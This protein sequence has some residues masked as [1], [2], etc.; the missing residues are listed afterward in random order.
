MTKGK[1]NLTISPSHRALAEKI[2]ALKRRSL[3]NLFEILIEEE[4]ARSGRIMETD[5]G[6]GR[7]R[8]SR[9]KLDDEA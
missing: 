6:Y 7:K 4:W 1:L 2:A 5:P 3:S 9:K 8:S